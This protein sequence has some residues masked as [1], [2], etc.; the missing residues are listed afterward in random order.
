MAQVRK[1]NV[2]QLFARWSKRDRAA[3]D[4]LVP[5]VYGELRRMAAPNIARLDEPDH[6][7]GLMAKCETPLSELERLRSTSNR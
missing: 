1:G 7:T 4:R 2:T 3:L 6:L 5:E